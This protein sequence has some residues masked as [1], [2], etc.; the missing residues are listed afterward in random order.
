MNAEITAPLS[1]PTMQPLT[2]QGDWAICVNAWLNGD[3][4][5]PDGDAIG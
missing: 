1:E 4:Q 2:Q 5:A 3:I